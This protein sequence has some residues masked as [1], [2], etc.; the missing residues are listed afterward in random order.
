[1]KRCQHDS[2]VMALSNIGAQLPCTHHVQVYAVE[3]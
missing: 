3:A 2:D 1:M